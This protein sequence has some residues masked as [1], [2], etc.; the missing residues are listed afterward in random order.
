M[1]HRRLAEIFSEW[2]TTDYKI[3]DALQSRGYSRRIAQAKPPLTEAS[4]QA[5]LA[6]ERCGNGDIAIYRGGNEAE[7]CSIG[8][9]LASGYIH[10][11]AK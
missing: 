7:G 10:K 3:R 2:D 1:S 11:H 4:R 5:R 8:R 9:A 6:C